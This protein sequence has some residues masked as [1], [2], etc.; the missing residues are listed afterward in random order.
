MFLY[1][2]VLQFLE[3]NLSYIFV[4]DTARGTFTCWTHGSEYTGQFQNGKKHGNGIYKYPDGVI[5]DGEWKEGIRE[6]D[7]VL[8]YI[9]GTKLIGK[10]SNDKYVG[11]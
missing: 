2:G 9:D 1:S 8:T 11:K 10:F 3:L 7:G 5:Y 6:G 4:S